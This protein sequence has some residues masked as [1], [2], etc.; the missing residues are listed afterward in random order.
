MKPTRVSDPAE[1]IVDRQERVL[2]ITWRDGHRS[3]Y[4]FDNLRRDCPCASC[5][6]ARN[7][8]LDAGNLLVLSGPIVMPGDVQITDYRPVGWYAL[9]FTWSDRHDTG[10]YTYESLRANCPCAGC[11]NSTVAGAER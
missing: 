11:A 5:N 4:S 2:I 1:V 6:D 3:V 7:K 8:R 10:I 9:N